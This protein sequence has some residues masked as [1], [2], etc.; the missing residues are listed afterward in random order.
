MFAVKA[1]TRIYFIR[2]TETGHIKIGVSIGT[3]VRLLNLQT[4][5]H[6]H[7]ES[8]GELRG[9]KCQERVLHRLFAAHRVLGEWFDPA[10]TPVVEV[11]L[12]ARHAQK[13]RRV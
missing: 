11:L 8:M 2:N 4:A 7:L 5:N 10:I 13:K 3:R 9:T 1:A 12:R 6:C